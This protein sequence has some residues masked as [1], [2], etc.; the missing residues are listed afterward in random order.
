MV[1]EEKFIEIVDFVSTTSRHDYEKLF[2]LLEDVL[3]K[4]PKRKS[5]I[6]IDVDKMIGYHLPPTTFRRPTVMSRLAD[7]ANKYNVGVKIGR[8]RQ[9]LYIYFFF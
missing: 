2:R 9:K 7:L 8:S 6:R 1:D 5:I 4:Y 3:K